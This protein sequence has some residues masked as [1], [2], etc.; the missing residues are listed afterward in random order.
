MHKI[1]YFNLGKKAISICA[2]FI[3]LLFVSSV[4]A[5][6]QT[7]G[8]VLIDN[9][10]N[11]IKIKNILKSISEEIEKI[12]IKIEQNIDISN[13]EIILSLGSSWY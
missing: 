3:V 2:V 8:S 12:T 1:K 10:N 9:V 7:N 13:N 11:N 5:V 4:T 6:P